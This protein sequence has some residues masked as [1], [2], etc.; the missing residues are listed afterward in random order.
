MKKMIYG[1]LFFLVLSAFNLPAQ[2][3]DLPDF[4]LN[5]PN[6]EDAIFGIGSGK[7]LT[8]AGSQQIAELRARMD[9]A[10]QIAFHIYTWTSDSDR[11]A[12]LA[13]DLYMFFGQIVC[14]DNAFDLIGYVKTVKTW[15]ASNGTA[16]CLV[17]LKKSDMAMFIPIF[18]KKF[19]QY[20]EDSGIDWDG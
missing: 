7:Q 5:P 9:I 20:L 17:E 14:L 3:A 13:S 16:W 11:F 2:N 4:L 12:Q 15:R 10:G 19:D 18:Q 6:R 8:D 1:L